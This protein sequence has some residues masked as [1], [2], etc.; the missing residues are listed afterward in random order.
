[1]TVVFTDDDFE[2]LASALNGVYLR[3]GDFEPVVDAARSGDLL[4][5]DPPYTVKH[6]S[7]GFVKYNEAIFRWADQVR[8]SK[9]VIRAASRGVKIVMLNADHD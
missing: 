7:N 8:L 4:F 3:E 5:L 1:M 9:S 2:G 6:N